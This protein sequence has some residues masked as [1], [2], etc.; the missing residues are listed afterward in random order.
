[1]LLPPPPAPP[2]PAPPVPAPPVPA[3]PAPP[4]PIPPAPPPELVLLLLLPL[5]AL[6]LLAAPVIGVVCSSS[7]PHA[8]IAAVALIEHR[9]ASQVEILMVTSLF[10]HP[11]RDFKWFSVADQGRS[12]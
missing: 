3:P 12:A 5:E 2:V 10:V 7:S 6:A 8:V 4:T 9:T 11:A 1:M